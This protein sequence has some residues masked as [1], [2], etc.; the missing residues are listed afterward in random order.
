MNLPK[1]WITAC[2]AC[3][4][5]RK[6]T[7]EGKKWD[8]RYDGLTLHDLRRSA[9]RNLINAGVR[10]RVVMQITGHKTRSVFD[11]RFACRKSF[12]AAPVSL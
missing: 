8:V 2:V 12:D 7:V 10:E 1:E 11:H 3:G 6:I 5:G 4:L 9:V